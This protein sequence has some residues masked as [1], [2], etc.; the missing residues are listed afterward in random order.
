MLSYKQIRLY[1]LILIALLS[2]G[3]S[4]D[5]ASKE[6]HNT[7]LTGSQVPDWAQNVVWYQIFPERF[8]NGDP[9]NDPTKERV[10]GPDDWE[11][12]RWTSDWYQ[13]TEWEK[14][15]GHSGRTVTRRRYGGDLQGVIDKLDYLKDLGITGI[16][17]NPLFDAMSMH[18]Y[19]GATFHHI[20]RFFGPDPEGDVEIMEQEDPSDPS[21]WQW[22]SADLLFLE[23]L[24]EAKKRDI[25]IIIDGVWNHTGRDFWAF[26]DVLEHKEN[27]RF[28]DWYKITTFSDEYEDGFDYEGWWGF[29]A[30]PEFKEI[31][32][33]LVP[34]VKAY[35]FAASSRWMA[36]NGLPEKGVDGWRL[37]VADYVGNDFWRD[38]HAHVKSINPEAFTVAEVWDDVARDMIADDRFSAVMNYRWTNAVHEFFIKQDIDAETFGNRLQT[39]L[40]DFPKPV[41]LSMQN[42][43]DSHDTE[44]LASQIVNR[45]HAFKEDS[46]INSPD[47]TYNVRKPNE[48]EIQLQ[49]LVALFQFT[50]LG[51]PMVYY[52]TE[53]GMWGA[54]DPDDRKPMIWPDLDYD[55]EVSHPFGHERPADAVYFDQD[56]FNWYQKLAGLRNTVP[57]LQ[58]GDVEWF[59]AE[60]ESDVFVFARI[61]NQEEYVLIFINRGNEVASFDASTL[62]GFNNNTLFDLISGETYNLENEQLRITIPAVSALVLSTFAPN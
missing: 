18:K 5:K 42:L 20:D 56:L 6:Y 8:R 43:M 19:D 12:T 50:W 34:E 46:K 30:L 48:D 16:W 24:E 40:D 23:L 13:Q 7:D 31:G 55:D 17:F 58:S 36:P 61:M 10:Y 45:D 57:A 27:S 62:S 49:K 26:Q 21:T 35:I 9:T 53:A 39:L 3:C 1:I 54:D 11:I 38:W 14:N 33:N 15:L 28:K 37:D 22:T 41:N 4:V 32:E 2:S 59:H 52:G 47:D 44:R 25:R 60:P 29:K 51:S